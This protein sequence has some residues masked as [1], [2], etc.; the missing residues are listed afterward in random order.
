MFICQRCLTIDRTPHTA[1]ST[2]RALHFLGPNYAV[3][4][5]ARQ[6]LPKIKA[7]IDH[8]VEWFGRTGERS[9]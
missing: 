2:F 7:C 6:R 9:A 8:W 5:G 1:H 3:T 4:A